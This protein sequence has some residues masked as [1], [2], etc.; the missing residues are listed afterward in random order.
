MKVSAE[1]KVKVCDGHGSCFRA[2]E[3]SA[4][5]C[6]HETMGFISMGE[7]VENGDCD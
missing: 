3:I 2:D 5:L 6:H 7:R 1:A 4:G